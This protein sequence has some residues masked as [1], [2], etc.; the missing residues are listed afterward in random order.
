MRL[1]LAFLLLSLCGCATLRKLA[2]P[3]K[4]PPPQYQVI[5][6][7]PNGS[8]SGS[9]AEKNGGP[10]WWQPDH[11]YFTDSTDKRVQ[12]D[13]EKPSTSVSSFS[14]F[15]GHEKTTLHTTLSGKS[16]SREFKV[17]AKTR[18]SLCPALEGSVTVYSTDKSEIGNSSTHLVTEECDG[19]D[20]IWNIQVSEKKSGASVG[21]LTYTSL[22]DKPLPS[23]EGMWEGDSVRMEARMNPDRYLLMRFYRGTKL[24]AV[25][26]PDRP[27]NPYSCGI[28]Y[29]W[30]AYF[31][32][33][34]GDAE[35]EKV[36]MQLALFNL[37]HRQTYARQSD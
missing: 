7:F 10:W 18:V 32:K 9:I 21:K 14:F 30:T 2:E 12:V 13:F 17:A 15:W 24:E 34:L 16:D 22:A 6:D 27:C 23:V 33:D 11:I 4:F 19:E 1:L 3:P 25:L 8:D 37:S 31:E 20:H 5:S 28:S 29:L 35:R 26:I 36:L